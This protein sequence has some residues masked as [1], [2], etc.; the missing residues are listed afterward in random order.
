VNHGDNDAS[1]SGQHDVA[2]P[3]GTASLDD[4]PDVSGERLLARRSLLIGGLVAVAAPI[5]VA[6]FVGR[7]SKIVGAPEF[8]VEDLTDEG[9]RVSLS[10][11]AGGPALVNFW[12]SWCV[13]CRTEMPILE[14]GFARF[15]NRVLFIGVDHQDSRTAAQAFVAKSGVQYRSGFDPDGTTAAAYGIRGLPTTVLVSA[16]GRLVETVTGALTEVRLQRLLSDG[17]GLK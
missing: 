6:A 8:T 14:A 4:T 2:P 17:L 3:E 11:R 9:A 15:G 7:R 1:L 5:G 10:D 12:A 16:G 13:P